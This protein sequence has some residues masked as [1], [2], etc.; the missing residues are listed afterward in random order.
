MAVTRVAVLQA[1]IDP[2][3]IT[4][5]PKAVGQRANRDGRHLREIVGAEHLH[6]VQAADRHV[7]E[8]AVRV[9]D[10]VDVVGDRAGVERPS[11]R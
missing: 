2:R 8:A 9:V 1:D 6:L 4:R 7:G 3:A 10:D 5:W 11:A